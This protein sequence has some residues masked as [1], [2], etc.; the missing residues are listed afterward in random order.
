MKQAST[1]VPALAAVAP[2]LGGCI[3]VN[4]STIR[5]SG[6]RAEETRNVP[7]FHAIELGVPGKAEIR[8][9][10]A[11]SLRLSC[12]D[13]LL[14]HVTTK[15]RRGVLEIDLPERYAFRE[16]LRLFITTPALD[17]FEIQGSGDAR[18]TD[19]DADE[20]ALAIEGSGELE[21]NGSVKR[22]KASIAGSGDMALRGLSSEQADVSISGSGDVALRVAELLKYRIQGSGDIRYIGA[23][24]VSGGVSGSGS[25]RR[26]SS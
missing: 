10:E 11:T 24:S 13:D 25:V 16:R 15:V 4:T 6:V 17:R 19:V 21:A 18:I 3:I 14:P 26:E 7:D 2:L 22:L 5:G 8:V 12:D 23:P 1:L 20:L 9:G